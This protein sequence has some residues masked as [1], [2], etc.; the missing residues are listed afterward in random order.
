M[1]RILALL[2]M[3]LLGQSATKRFRT[4]QPTVRPT[5]RLV[6]KTRLVAPISTILTSTSPLPPR[7]CD[8]L[9]VGQLLPRLLSFEQDAAFTEYKVK[10]TYPI[11]ANLDKVFDQDKDTFYSLPSNASN[12]LSIEFYFG[13]HDHWRTPL[14]SDYWRARV[15][16]GFTITSSSLS[17]NYD[18][19]RWIFY[20]P[21]FCCH[22]LIG[23]CS[24]GSEVA[25]GSFSAW[26]R[27]ETRL[28]TFQ[29]THAAVGYTLVL[30]G[31][32]NSP[33]LAT[34]GLAIAEIELT[35]C[36][37]SVACAQ[38]GGG[39]QL[40]TLLRVNLNRT[41]TVQNAR[42]V[43]DPY[44]A[45]LVDQDKT[46]VYRS[47]YTGM[48]LL[49]TFER[50]QAVTGYTITSSNLSSTFDPVEWTLLGS[51]KPFD[52]TNR[53]EFSVTDR[54]SEWIRSETRLFNF[55]NDF[56]YRYY[57]MQLRNTKGVGGL[58]FVENDGLAIGEIELI[59][60]GES[61]SFLNRACL[62]YQNQSK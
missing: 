4:S 38:L 9:L 8:K 61:L 26:G 36:G 1:I 7:T 15:V 25:R 40:P 50:E 57:K 52:T 60:C 6:Q 35:V 2:C 23:V 29:N 46:T 17:A 49:F 16:S 47:D 19:V 53:G 45:N 37:G 14:E 54:Y 41:L 11:S 48:I 34:N 44:V 59:V 51:T 31:A 22:G 10:S 55:K 32:P 56:P 39:H 18:P 27:S 5:K 21:T 43:E 42:D 20:S 12:E 13:V 3:A 24:R 58:L 62:C 30:Y 28:F 33:G